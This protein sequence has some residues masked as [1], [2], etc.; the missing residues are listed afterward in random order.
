MPSPPAALSEIR[1]V[2]RPGGRLL[3]LEHVRA[4]EDKPLVRL[5]QA[6]L[7]PLQQTMGD[8]CS[9]TRETLKEVAQAGFETGGVRSL[10]VEGL[11]LFSSHIAGLA[12]R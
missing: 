8:G 2:L 5:A 1:R 10:Q 4:P 3:L 7:T 11:S 12:R 9:L 6:V